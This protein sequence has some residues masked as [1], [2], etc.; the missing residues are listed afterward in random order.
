MIDGRWIVK[1]FL[2][3]G[4]G[5]PTHHTGLIRQIVVAIR[6]G[7]F[8]GDPQRSTLGRCYKLD[9]SGHKGENL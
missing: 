8:Q 3:D 9:F 1:L 6:V 4:E 2:I 5:Y 7:L